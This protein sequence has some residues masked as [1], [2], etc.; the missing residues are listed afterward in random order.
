MDFK[1]IYHLYKDLVY[2]LCLSYLPN[3]EDAEDATQEVF[4]KIHKQIAS[5][6]G[7]AALKTWIYRI[8]INYCL[9]VLK[10]QKRVKRFAFISS[11]FYP[12][13]NQIK[14]DLVEFKHPGTQLEQK[15]ALALLF[16]HINNLP[17]QQKTV[18][19]LAKIEQLPLKEV[20]EIMN[21]TPKS[22]ESLLGRAKQNLK[23]K[24]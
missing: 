17:K 1:E 11:I 8:A 22:V 7:K 16:G 3:T 2:N 9:D 10:A 12:N 19:I 15:E 5:Y 13:S 24:Y 18:L 23:K 4:V 6:Q 14:H 21:K 20:A